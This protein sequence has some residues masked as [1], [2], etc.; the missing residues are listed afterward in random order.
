MVSETFGLCS[1]IL[2][3]TYAPFSLLTKVLTD[4]GVVY[5]QKGVELLILEFDNSL[6][7]GWFSVV[8]A[9]LFALAVYFMERTSTL[10]FGRKLYLKSVSSYSLIRVI[11]QHFGLENS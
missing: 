11:Q 10:S 1:S 3:P 4:V 8:V 2:S 6:Q 7:I 5:I 9:M